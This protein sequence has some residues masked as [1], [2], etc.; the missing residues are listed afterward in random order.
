MYFMAFLQSLYI[1]T[2]QRT[3]GII[4]GASYILIA[5]GHY[6]IFSSMHPLAR[7]NV[8]TALFLMVSLFVY[9]LPRWT[10][11]VK[12]RHRSFII[13]WAF[14]FG[15]FYWIIQGLAGIFF[16]FGKSPFDQHIMSIM[17][18]IMIYGIPIIARELVRSY[19][20]HGYPHKHKIRTGIIITCALTFM[21]FSLTTYQELTTFQDFVEFMGQQFLPTLCQQALITVLSYMAGPIPAIIYSI[22]ITFPPYIFPILPDLNWLVSAFIGILTPVFFLIMLQVLS[23]R[24]LKVPIKHHEK[25]NPVTLVLTIVFSICIIWFSSGVFA[26]YPSV[27]ATGSMEPMIYPGDVILVRKINEDNIATLQDGD[28]IQ[29][30]REDI[31]ISHR[32]IEIVRL[33]GEIRYRTKGDN[34]SCEDADLVLQENVKGIITAVLPKIG[35]PTLILKRDRNIDRTAIEF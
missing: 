15:F 27:I 4:L 22:M 11:G 8:T 26:V 10:H 20:L 35:W 29:F 31:L 34:N 6:H 9:F 30:K 2:S 12:T 28:V 32:I 1:R 3:N 19:L 13:W 5:T 16:S 21:A 17:K 33:N 25:E 24:E 14:I 23:K 18:N 7:Q